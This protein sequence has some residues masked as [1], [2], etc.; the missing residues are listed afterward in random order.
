MSYDF[1]LPVQ[2]A[3]EQAQAGLLTRYLENWRARKAVKS[4][5]QLDDYLLRDLGVER[6]QVDWAASQPLSVNAAFALD[7]K[8]RRG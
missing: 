7:E 5:L 8:V 2:A 6:A 1:S 3:Y 4:L